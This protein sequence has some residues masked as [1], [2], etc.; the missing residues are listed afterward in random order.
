MG[1]N[2]GAL[3]GEGASRHAL[4]DDDS[5]GLSNNGF[6]RDFPSWAVS[7]QC[8]DS[9]PG[10]PGG[11][12]DA[13]TRPPA[14][15]RGAS[16]REGKV[17]EQMDYRAVLCRGSLGTLRTSLSALGTCCLQKPR[18][19]AG[20]IPTV[21]RAWKFMQEKP[22]SENRLL[23]PVSQRAIKWPYENLCKGSS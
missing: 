18:A 13:G 22:G 3:C 2:R 4:A 9:S 14:T 1:R 15:G 19:P 10:F 6:L 23:A 20:R 16:R 8:A 17:W 5:R 7:P 21:A 12:A 11:G